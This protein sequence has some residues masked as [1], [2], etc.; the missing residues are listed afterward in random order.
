MTLR[1]AGRHLQAAVPGRRGPAGAAVLP[2]HRRDQPGRH[3]PDLRRTAD[4]HREGQAGQA[5]H[6]A[7]EPDGVP[8]PAERP[9]HRHDEHGG[10]LDRPARY[11]P[12]AAVRVRRVDAGLPHCCGRL[13]SPSI[14]LGPWLDAL[15]RR[16]CEHVGRD[17]RNLQ[18][19]HSF[20][21]EAGRPVKDAARFFRVVRDE[22]IPLLEEYC[23]EDF[24]ALHNI[25]GNGLVDL[26]NRA[27]RHDLFEE[28]TGPELVAG[29][30]GTLPGHPDLA[31]GR[32]DRRGRR[33]RGRAG[34]G[35]GRGRRRPR[36]RHRHP[37]RRVADDLARLRE[38]DGGRRPRR[39]PFGA[40]PGPSALRRPDAGGPGASHGP[41]RRDRPRS[42]GGSGSARS[43]SPSSPSCGPRP[44]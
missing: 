8:G 18:V 11:R 37:A 21:L 29:P 9:P 10:P 36:D 17:A 24:D 44:S 14:P 3:P 39:R 13:R 40:G 5:G 30:P 2:D 7:A 12:A 23:Y 25:L 28:P 38:P 43:R 26:P 42:S 34:R 35:R 27:I 15:N 22:I 1:P 6:P 31:P 32:H 41:G 33:G 16:I 19:G 4:G 20:L